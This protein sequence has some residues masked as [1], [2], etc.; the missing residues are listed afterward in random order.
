VVLGLRNAAGHRA[1]LSC[2]WVPHAHFR[3]VLRMSATGLGIPGIHEVLQ[4]KEELVAP[5]TSS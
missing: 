1:L 4:K 5:G 3:P 2:M